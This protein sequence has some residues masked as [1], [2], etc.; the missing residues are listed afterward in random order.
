VLS[1]VPV[2]RLSW[3]SAV[4][5]W[6]APL[7]VVA[8]AVVLRWTL[9]ADSGLGFD[10]AWH[11][12]LSTGRGSA[13]LTLPWNQAIPDSQAV[14]S[15]EGAGPWWS[16]WRGMRE[17]THPPLYVLVLRVWEELF[18]Q[19]VLALRGLSILLSAATVGLLFAVVRAHS[20]AVAAAWSAALLAVAPQQ[21]VLGQEVRGYAMLQLLGVV[22]VAC[23][24]RLHTTTRPGLWA[25][26][27]GV[28]LLA[29]VFTHYF[30]AAAFLATAVFAMVALKGNRR[31]MELAAVLV[32]TVLF[33]VAWLPT[34][35]GQWRWVAGTGD[36]VLREPVAGHALRT[37]GRLASLPVRQLVETDG[38]P[39]LLGWLPLV[40]AACYLLPWLLRRRPELLVWGVWLASVAALVG[41][42][43]LAR[44]TRHLTLLR[45]T[46]LVAPAVCALLA[47]VSCSRWRW[48][49]N[50]V[51]AAVL[52]LCALGR[53]T[54]VE[55]PD[56]RSFGRTVEDVVG[57]NEPL[58]F[59]GGPQRAWYFGG[60]LQL[61]ASF[62]AD[63]WPRTV[64]RKTSDAAPISLADLGSGTA[65]VVSG[66]P[67]PDV[68]SL[69]PGCRPIAVLA[70]RDIA[71]LVRIELPGRLPAQTTP[72]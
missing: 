47:S 21:V 60:V 8:L 1:S 54:P 32:P 38:L 26:G 15:L 34:A 31:W 27:L 18:G 64:L 71:Y 6:L 39:G 56:W 51:P 5:G 30:G 66:P 14:T 59:F 17:A 50:A 68:A 46:C 52:L 10:E 23:L 4:L 55:E 25:T 65:W 33:M 61:G 53:P 29:L 69:F 22:A 62:H 57:R 70:V 3:G 28:T 44:T 16:P 36:L 2:R 20:G 72:R 40:G 49:R 37:L 12:E 7:A 9:G 35:L 63:V 19:S 43:D 67:S 11:V 41:G 58:V 45:Y 13:H 48:L 24:L 42:L